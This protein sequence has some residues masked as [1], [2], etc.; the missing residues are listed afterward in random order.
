LD[1]DIKTPLSAPV[2]INSAIFKV[3]WLCGC[4]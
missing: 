3:V 1:V 2:L 4:G